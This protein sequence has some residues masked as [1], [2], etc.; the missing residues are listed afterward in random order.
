MTIWLRTNG[1]IFSALRQV[2][3]I[4]GSPAGAPPPL[5]YH[6]TQ[7]TVNQ[8]QALARD[9]PDGWAAT[10]RLHLRLNSPFANRLHQSLVVM[11]ILDGVSL[12]KIGQ[13]ILKGGA[14]AHI[15]G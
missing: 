1:P 8:N 13:G 14:V 9:Q 6:A 7:P 4:E 2:G 12:A 3:M 5:R 11:F 15:A 10:L